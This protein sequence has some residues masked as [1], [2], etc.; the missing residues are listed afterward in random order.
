MAW[1]L[2]ALLAGPLMVPAGAADNQLAFANVQVTTDS[3]DHLV[4]S[5]D[6]KNLSGTPV[7]N[8]WVQMTLWDASGASAVCHY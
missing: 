5:G 3:S 6:L 2:F 4:A 8:I 7:V 1:G